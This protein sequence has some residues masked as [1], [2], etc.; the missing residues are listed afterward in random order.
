MEGHSDKS[1]SLSVDSGGLIDLSVLDSDC[2]TGDSSLGK[3]ISD[4]ILSS[5]ILVRV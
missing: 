1:S 4:R 5:F 2:K 3:T